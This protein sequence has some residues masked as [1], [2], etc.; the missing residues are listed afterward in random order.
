MEEDE[1]SEEVRRREVKPAP[2]RKSDDEAPGRFWEVGGCIRGCVIEGSRG[3][4]PE[5]S[6][7]EWIWAEEGE[8][9][10]GRM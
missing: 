5:R 9:V 4:I 8:E 7:V 10:G 6:S 1:R 3:G 2:G